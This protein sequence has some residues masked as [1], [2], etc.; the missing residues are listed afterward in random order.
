M[1]RIGRLNNKPVVIGNENKLTKNEILLKNESDNKVSLSVNK[2]GGV[3]LITGGRSSC[4]YYK[5]RW[6]DLD[7]ILMDLTGDLSEEDAQLFFLAAISYFKALENTQYYFVEDSSEEYCNICLSNDHPYSKYYKDIAASPL[8]WWMHGSANYPDYMIFMPYTTKFFDHYN[9][10]SKEYVMGEKFINEIYDIFYL[11]EGNIVDT[12]IID[13][14]K[15]LIV[16]ITEEEFNQ[17]IQT[18]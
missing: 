3:E 16:P 14:I 5:F 4:K 17:A 12:R 8:E 6:N 7:S 15:A 2:G 13:F 11:R 1:K 9:Y 18:K 10:D